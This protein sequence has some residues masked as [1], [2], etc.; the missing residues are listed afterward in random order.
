MGALLSLIGGALAVV[1]PGARIRRSLC[2]SSMGVKYSGCWADYYATR[3]AGP[4]TTLRQRALETGVGVE[5]GVGD[6]ALELEEGQVRSSANLILAITVAFVL[7]AGL[8][9][10]LCFARGTE[11]ASSQLEN[12]SAP[13]NMPCH[14]KNNAPSSGETRE[15]CDRD[16]SRVDSVAFA[17][18]G[19]RT[20]LDAP[21]AALAVTFFDL[22][23]P[24]NAAPVG[25]FELALAPPPR[26]LLLV[27]NSFLI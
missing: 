26:N 21:A 15:D 10:A 8:C 22:V 6:R 7:Q 3:L 19:T 20:L 14:D 17:L 13:V 25:E 18:S 4:I 27:K 11:P 12:A 2:V 1:L 16:C 23:P 5:K 24:A 9:P